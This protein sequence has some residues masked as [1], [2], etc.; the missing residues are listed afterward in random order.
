ML[1]GLFSGFSFL[2]LMSLV[3]CSAVGKRN[4]KKNKTFTLLLITLAVL[5]ALS[6]FGISH[7]FGAFATTCGLV[8]SIVTLFVPFV[9]VKKKNTKGLSRKVMK[10]IESEYIEEYLIWSDTTH[11]PSLLGTMSDYYRLLSTVLDPIEE[12]H[13]E[14]KYH[15][16][17]ILSRLRKIDPYT[18]TSE[19]NT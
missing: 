7:P 13:P 17:E 9:T 14:I 11:G 15:Y 8:F 19:S 4:K 2:A 18:H 12:E 6:A 5:V 3:V 1:I 16:E 10:K